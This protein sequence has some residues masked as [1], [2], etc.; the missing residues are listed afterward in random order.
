MSVGRRVPSRTARARLLAALTLLAVTLPACSNSI[1]G[2]AAE[3][4]IETLRDPAPTPTAAR[5]P[6]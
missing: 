3:A 4:G 1:L 5:A 6:Q 2:N